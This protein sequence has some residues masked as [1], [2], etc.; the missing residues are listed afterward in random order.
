MDK[1]KVILDVDTGADDA[2]AIMLAL[3]APELEVIGICSVNGNREVKL[4][5]DN[6]LRVKALMGSDV[7][8]YRGCEYPMVAT[9]TPG[10]KPGIPHREGEMTGVRSLVHGDHLPLPVDQQFPNRLQNFPHQIGLNRHEH[11][12]G[13]ERDLGRVFPGKHARLLRVGAQL[14]PVFCTG[15]NLVRPQ[16]AL[17]N[18]P[19]CD[20]AGH[21]AEADKSHR[22]LR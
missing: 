5:T 18:Q 7:P 1:R 2:V 8:V 4:T 6:T 17:A 20:G 16:R 14:V 3:L 12:I 9:L 11:H 21:V 15:T 22:D 13:R 19:L 10:R